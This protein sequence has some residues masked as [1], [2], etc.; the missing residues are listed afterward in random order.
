MNWKKAATVEKA[1][2]KQTKKYSYWYT[3]HSYE[4]C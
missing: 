1:T 4:V 3:S 2:N